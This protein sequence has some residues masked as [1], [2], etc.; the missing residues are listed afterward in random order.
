VY[1]GFAEIWLWHQFWIKRLAVIMQLNFQ[2]RWLWMERKSHV[3]SVFITLTIAIGMADNICTDFMRRQL[4]IVDQS[5][6]RC[7]CLP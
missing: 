4:Y 2:A 7:T 5:F 1:L 3:N 6:I